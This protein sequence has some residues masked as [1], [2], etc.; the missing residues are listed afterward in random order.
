MCNENPSIA[1]QAS[2]GSYPAGT[3]DA[4]LNDLKNKTTADFPPLQEVYYEIN[5][6]HGSL[7]DHLSRLFI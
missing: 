6:V 1:A 4:M 3:W 2:T 7:Q 5:S